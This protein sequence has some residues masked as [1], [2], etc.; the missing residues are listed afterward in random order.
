MASEL[1]VLP[2]S[3]EK[4]NESRKKMYVYFEILFKIIHIEKNPPKEPYSHGEAG[5][6][7]VDT[8]VFTTEDFRVVF[9]HAHL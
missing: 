9:C 1:N 6:L 5:V 2:L 7:P 3:A 8:F 4:K